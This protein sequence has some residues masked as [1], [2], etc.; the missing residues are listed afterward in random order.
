MDDVYSVGARQRRVH[1]RRSA[2]VLSVHKDPNLPAEL[3]RFVAYLVPKS[4]VTL[5]EDIDHHTHRA[6]L[7]LLALVRP[8]SP[9]PTIQTDLE[10]GF[11][12]AQDGF[13]GPQL[14][15]FGPVHAARFNV[16]ALK[17]PR[18]PET[19]LCRPRRRPTLDGEVQ[20]RLHL[21]AATQGSERR[22]R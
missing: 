20:T 13:S 9:E 1:S 10:H 14:I 17:I 8:K 22:S 2:D 21:W 6:G 11:E 18:R 4:W 7:D 15:L 12:R 3:P 19:R 16:R 5:F